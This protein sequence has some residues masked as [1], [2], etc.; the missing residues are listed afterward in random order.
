[1]NE[2]ATLNMKPD[3]FYCIPYFV[4]R[5][6]ESTRLEKNSKIVQSNHT[7]TTNVSPLNHIP[8]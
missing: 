2:N 7:P 6:I 3:Q 4:H 8:E 5:I 1:M